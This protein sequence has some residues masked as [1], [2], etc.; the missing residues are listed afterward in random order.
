MSTTFYLFV[1]SVVHHFVF[2]SCIYCFVLPSLFDVLHFSLAWFL[3]LSTVRQSKGATKVSEVVGGK[4]KKFFVLLYWEIASRLTGRIFRFS[5]SCI[6]PSTALV[7]CKPVIRYRKQ[8][9][10]RKTD[11]TVD[12]YLTNIQHL[13][14]ITWNRVHFDD[15]GTRVAFFSI[16]RMHMPNIRWIYPFTSPSLPQMCRTRIQILGNG[17]RCSAGRAL[18]MNPEVDS[19]AKA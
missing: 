7:I 10:G 11:K 3:V 19:Q 18:H 6:S 12:A 2:G 8:L 14:S 17:L 16:N 5:R 4:V 13:L 9:M 15:E 1:C